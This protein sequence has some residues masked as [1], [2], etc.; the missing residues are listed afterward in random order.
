M[1]HVLGILLA[2]A[3]FWALAVSMPRHQRDLA[4]RTLA[5]SHAFT[6]RWAGWALLAAALAVDI[7]G[8]GGGYG[9]VAWCAHLTVG[10]WLT[11]ALLHLPKR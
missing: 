4:G 7:A 2:L 8:L 11:V 6:A 3:G 10:A 1:T 5:K 9:L